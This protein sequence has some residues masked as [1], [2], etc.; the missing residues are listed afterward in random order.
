MPTVFSSVSIMA[1]AV[2]AGRCVGLRVSRF[3][4]QFPVTSSNSLIVAAA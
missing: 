1:D 4:I 3:A 2:S